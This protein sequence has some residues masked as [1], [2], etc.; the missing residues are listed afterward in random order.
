M[1]DGST[2]HFNGCGVAA[3]DG[4][5]FD[6][7]CN[8]VAARMAVRTYRTI[9]RPSAEAD[10]EDPFWL[11]VFAFDLDRLHRPPTFEDYL[12]DCQNAWNEE[13]EAPRKAVDL[14]GRA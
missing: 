11:K 9:P 10:W 1:F 2:G 7:F 6:D 5:C 14:G 12:R 8:L 13:T 3:C 4:S